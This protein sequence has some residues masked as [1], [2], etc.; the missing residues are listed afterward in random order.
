LS[1]EAVQV[2]QRCFDTLPIAKETLIL[3]LDWACKWNFLIVAR[4]R[5]EVWLRQRPRLQPGQRCA[6]SVHQIS[7]PRR[8]G[9]IL[10]G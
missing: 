5:G 3:S 6:P 1:L 10:P 2:F 4:R 8:F 7:P 9:R